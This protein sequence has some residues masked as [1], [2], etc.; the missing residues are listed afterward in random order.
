MVSNNGKKLMLSEDAQDWNLGEERLHFD[1]NN[2][3]QHN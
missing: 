2:I 1:R 3:E